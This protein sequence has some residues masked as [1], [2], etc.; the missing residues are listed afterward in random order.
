MTIDTYFNIYG[1]YH[2][3][4]VKKFSCWS[5]KIYDKDGKIITEIKGLFVK[6]WLTITN[7]STQIP[8]GQ[9][10]YKTL[11][12]GTIEKYEIIESKY[13]RGCGQ[14]SDFYKLTL[15]ENTNKLMGKYRIFIIIIQYI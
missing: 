14:V 5:G 9:I 11:P 8:E 12:N 2:E 6:T 7:V 13:V 1:G 3:R 4:Y 10:I 15:I